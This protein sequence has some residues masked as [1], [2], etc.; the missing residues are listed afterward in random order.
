MIARFIDAHGHG[1]HGVS[2]IE[3]GGDQKRQR[4]RSLREDDREHYARIAPGARP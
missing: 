3:P 1:R 2:R 4:E